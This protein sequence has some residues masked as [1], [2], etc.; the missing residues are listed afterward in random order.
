[1][2]ATN[3]M[4]EDMDALIESKRAVLEAVLNQGKL[5]PED[6][7]IRK[8]LLAAVA[9]RVVGKRKKGAKRNVRKRA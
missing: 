4:D 8:E 5:L 6:L 2:V 1:M 9:K 7:D 3:T